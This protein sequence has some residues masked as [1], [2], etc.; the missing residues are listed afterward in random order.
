[1]YQVGMK[2]YLLAN[3][4]VFCWQVHI[5]NKIIIKMFFFLMSIEPEQSQLV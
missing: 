3:A 1:M 2:Y 4:F 5:R